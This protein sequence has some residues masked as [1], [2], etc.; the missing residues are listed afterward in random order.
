MTRS[1]MP[2][3]N[4]ALPYGEENR[5]VMLLVSV[6]RFENRGHSRGHDRRLSTFLMSSANGVCQRIF[7]HQ[8]LQ[9]LQPVRR[10]CARFDD[11]LVYCL[12]H[13]KVLPSALFGADGGTSLPGFSLKKPFGFS[14]NPI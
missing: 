10:R 12:Q 13:G 11:A 9:E 14:R 8:A 7:F 4:S 3:P 6:S 2:V 5:Y 1:C